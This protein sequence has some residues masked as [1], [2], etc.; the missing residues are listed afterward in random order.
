M[1]NRESA[2]KFMKGQLFVVQF[3]VEHPYVFLLD[4]GRQR[5]IFIYAIW[6]F[7]KHMDANG[8]PITAAFVTKYRS[9]P[10]LAGPYKEIG[11]AFHFGRDCDFSASVDGESLEKE[12]ILRMCFFA[13]T[14][15]GVALASFYPAMGKDAQMFVSVYSNKKKVRIIAQHLAAAWLHEIWGMDA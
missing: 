12:R 1:I 9:E 7:V 10:G 4:E 11:L 2:E 14:D 13:N 5:N 15:H 3:S 6:G 8:K